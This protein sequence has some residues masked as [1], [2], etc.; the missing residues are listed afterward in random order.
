MSADQ[1]DDVDDDGDDDV[2][3]AQ[4]GRLM[5]NTNVYDM[6]LYGRRRLLFP[7]QQHNEWGI[8]IK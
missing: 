3:S 4:P 8:V 5:C 7:L 2:S 6:R 1:H